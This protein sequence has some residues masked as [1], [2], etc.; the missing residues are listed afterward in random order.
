MHIPI[1][2]DFDRLMLL[3]AAFV[4]PLALVVPVALLV[5]TIQDFRVQLLFRIRYLKLQ[6]FYLQRFLVVLA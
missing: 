5:P 3:V 2:R 1:T 6:R 4:F